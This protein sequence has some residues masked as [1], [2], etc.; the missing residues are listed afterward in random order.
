MYLIEEDTFFC[1][2]P[3]QAKLIAI[4]LDSRYYQDSLLAEQ[5]EQLA[6]QEYLIEG[7]DSTLSLLK[8]KAENY[9]SIIEGQRKAFRETSLQL[10][11]MQ[12]QVKRQ[13]R[14]KIFLGTGLGISLGVIGFLGLLN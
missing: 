14:G 1:F 10:G 8:N 9:R 12:R 5:A 13:K 4:T 6:L 2:L 3:H 11:N 7:Q